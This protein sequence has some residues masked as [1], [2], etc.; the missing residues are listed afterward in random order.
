MGNQKMDK[1]ES[2]ETKNTERVAILID[3][4][5]FYKNLENLNLDN[6][7]SFL[8]KDFASFLSQ[9]RKIVC[10]RYYKGSIIRELNN[11][12]SEKMYSAQQKLFSNLE[13]QDYKVER[14]YMMKYREY[15]KCEGFYAIDKKI[16]NHK[17][18][19]E[20]GK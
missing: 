20:I 14:G 4:N 17:Q 6:I 10:A 8:Y 13:K 5:N 12:K 15:K 11:P 18:L 16:K 2:G 19:K 7:Q 1:I 9:G 3:G